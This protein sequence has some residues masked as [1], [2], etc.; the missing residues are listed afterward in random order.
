MTKE[1]RFER[2]F[3]SKA[4]VTAIQWMNC[5]ACDKF[6]CDNAHVRSR[7][8][9]GG[10][11]NNIVPLCRKCHNELHAIGN[12][13]FEYKYDVNLKEEAIRIS[14]NIDGDLTLDVGVD[15]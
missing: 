1:E 14:R 4:R 10:W 15:N 7:G 3:G 5:V 2:A 13:R 12:E 8:V 11:K 6:G 9:G